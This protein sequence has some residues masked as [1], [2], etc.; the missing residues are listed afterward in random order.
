MLSMDEPDHRRLRDIVDEAFR[1][2]AVLEMEPRI[3]AIAEELA[4][5]L[6]TAGTPA[7]LVARYLRELPLSLICGP[8]RLPL[9][10][11]PMFTPWAGG[12]TRFPRPVRPLSL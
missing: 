7:D 10:V 1:R 8:L 11:L 9:A 6:F 12:L 4:G 2:R 5:D 3:L